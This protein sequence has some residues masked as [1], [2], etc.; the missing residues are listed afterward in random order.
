LEEEGL[1]QYGEIP[2]QNITNFEVGIRYY[3][4][5]YDVRFGFFNTRNS[6]YAVPVIVKSA[7]ILENNAGYYYTSERKSNGLNVNFKY[8]YWNIL[9]AANAT[10]YLSKDAELV[11]SPSF[12]FDG[13][14]YYVDTMFNKNLD[15]KAGFNFKFYTSQNFFTYDFER[16]A[17][18]QRIKTSLTSADNLILKTSDVFRVDFFLAGKVQDLAV[19]YF[20]FENLLD[21]KYFI[22]PYYPALGRNIRFG[23]SW[24]FLD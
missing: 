11:N 8:K 16:F 20:T 13:G 19:I 23:V 17:S 10:T 12:T 6:S 22:V 4:K 7:G 3:K 9:F 1:A 21:K 14:F 2:S 15:L 24:E 18:A 5:D